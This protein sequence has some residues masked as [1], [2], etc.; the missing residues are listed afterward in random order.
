MKILSVLMSLEVLIRSSFAL[1][2]AAA[3][4]QDCK[5]GSVSTKN[6]TKNQEYSPGFSSATSESSDN[7]ASNAA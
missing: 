1:G 7:S 6:R 2:P 3:I 4:P 5:A